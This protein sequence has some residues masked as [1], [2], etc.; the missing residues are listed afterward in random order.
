MHKHKHI[1][2]H[3]HH[4][5]LFGIVEVHLLIIGVFTYLQQLLIYFFFCLFTGDGGLFRICW[6]QTAAM[7]S[8]QLNTGVLEHV[9]W[10]IPSVATS[11]GDVVSVNLNY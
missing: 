2:N 6:Y 11:G 7:K 3:L 9:D 5:H 10:D 4:T 8:S 1:F